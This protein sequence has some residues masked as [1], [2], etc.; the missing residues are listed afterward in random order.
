MKTKLPP[1]WWQFDYLS[2]SCL[3]LYCHPQMDC[4][5]RTFPSFSRTIYLKRKDFSPLRRKYIFANQIDYF[6]NGAAFLENCPV[7]I[8]GDEA[9]PGSGRRIIYEPEY[10]EVSQPR[11]FLDCL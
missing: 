3:R 5:H 10:S 6:L 11:I 4:L 7:T 9:I 2:K 8:R 1:S